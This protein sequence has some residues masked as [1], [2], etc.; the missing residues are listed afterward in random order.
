[1]VLHEE[2]SC[3]VGPTLIYHFEPS[4]ALRHVQM[5]DATRLL[6]R[7]M[8]K[9]GLAKPGSTETE[10]QRL[11]ALLEVHPEPSGEERKH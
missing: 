9:R 8:E 7:D 5:I 2:G 4:M 11:A 1:V 10:P 6:M 3:G